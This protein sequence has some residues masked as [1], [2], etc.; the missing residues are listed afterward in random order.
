M[1]V[2]HQLGQWLDRHSWWA[3]FA[4]RFMPGTRLPLY[5][6]AGM[7]GVRAWR[8]ILWAFISDTVWTPLIVL[9]VAY[10]GDVVVRPFEFFFGRGWLSLAAAVLAIFI[11]VRVLV[12][13]LSRRGRWRLWV[14]L[15]KLWRWEFWPMWLFYAP[16]V[17]YLLYLS[18][19]YRSLTCWTA[20][21]P[22]IPQGGVVGESKQQILSQLPQ[23]WV[24][25]YYLVAPGQTAA[26]VQSLLDT[27]QQRGWEFSV[28]VKP[29]AAQRG[30]GLKLVKNAGEVQTHLES[31]RDPM[32]AQVYH[33]GPYE[34]GIFYYRYPD[35]AAGHI[36]SITDK[37]FPQ[38]VGDGES[39]LEELIWRHPRLRMQAR[40][41]SSRYADTLDQ[42]PAVDEKINLAVAGNH[43]QG[44]LFKDGS[45]LITDELTRTIDDIAKQFDGFYFGRFD[46]RYADEQSVKGGN[47]FA[48]IELNGVTSESTN[49]YDPSWSIFSAYAT[50]MRQ[51]SILFRIGDQNR[52]RGHRAERIGSLLKLVLGYY[53][54]RSG[55]ALSD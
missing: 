16:L 52:R 50:L 38:V 20:A 40:V 41:F 6:S 33:P 51:W 1:V 21:D 37:A 18:L 35:D 4:S 17:P 25:D 53:R 5:V 30:Y 23:Q 44:A 2:G 47:D 13:C 14:R 24:A 55:S 34:A 9:V 39:T 48:I 45:H 3:V 22:G 46:V 42:V 43:C 8:F 29:D 54:K 49:I 32:L 28:I 15:S 12:A 27:M 26:R 7:L 10:F 36:F 19:R 31:H 11:L